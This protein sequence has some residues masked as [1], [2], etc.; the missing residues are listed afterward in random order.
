MKSENRKDRRIDI[1]EDIMFAR[2]SAH[3]YCYYGATALNYSLSGMCFTS[4]YQVEPGVKLC[5]RMIGKHLQTFSSLDELT[6]I[7][8]VRWCNQTG[9]PDKPNYH[10]GLHY[11]DELIPPLFKP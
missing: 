2:R 9:P 3:P 7:A 1:H 8:E 11:M 5:L 6:C 10:I 4:R